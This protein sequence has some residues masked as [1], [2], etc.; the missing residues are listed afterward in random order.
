MRIEQELVILFDFQ[1]Q[2]FRE[3]SYQKNAHLVTNPPYGK[4][5]GMMILSGLYSNLEKYI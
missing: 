5:M 1:N 4:R 2:I 3:V